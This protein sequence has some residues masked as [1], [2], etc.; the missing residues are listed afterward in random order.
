MEQLSCPVCYEIFGD[1]ILQCSLGHSICSTCF[2]KTTLCAQ[3]RQPYTG[4]RNFLLEEM[5]KQL[6][7]MKSATDDIPDKSTTSEDDAVA[8]KDLAEKLSKQLAKLIE[9]VPKSEPIHEA[10]NYNEIEHPLII[11]D[12][13]DEN[14]IPNA[15]I[16]K[17]FVIAWTFLLLLLLLL[18]YSNDEFR[19]RFLQLHQNIQPSHVVGSVAVFS[20]VTNNLP[21]VVC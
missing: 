19:L 11:L 4:T 13:I 6:I 12:R 18:L 20:I 9:A 14:A 7:Q 15:T 17:T 5:V 8:N 1:R 16:G 10:D 21:A 2:S 3:C